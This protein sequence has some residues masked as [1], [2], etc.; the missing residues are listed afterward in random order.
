VSADRPWDLRDVEPIGTQRTWA[1][2]NPGGLEPID[3]EVYPEEHVEAGASLRRARVWVARIGLRQAADRLGL[4]VV[5]LSAVERGAMTGDVGG[6]VRK[7][8][9]VGDG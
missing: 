9:E 1:F 8:G 2:V 4:T 3:M 5:E 7:L 6:M